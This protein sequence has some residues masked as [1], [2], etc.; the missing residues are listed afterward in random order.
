MNI[1]M[2]EGRDTCPV[3]QLILVTEGEERK[4]AVAH[5]RQV[6]QTLGRVLRDPGQPRKG[7]ETITCVSASTEPSA[8]SS[9]VVVIL[10][11]GNDAAQSCNSIHMTS[12]APRST[13]RPT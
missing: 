1:S 13:I 7:I 6:K 2:L 12:H 8:E 10:R 4:K 5:I 9:A 3:R 11:L